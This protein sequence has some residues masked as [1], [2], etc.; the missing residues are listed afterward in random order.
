MKNRGRLYKGI[1]G[2]CVMIMLYVVLFLVQCKKS[3]G[4]P[5]ANLDCSKISS[6]YSANIRPI[7]TSAACSM[8][9]CHNA[10]SQY[11]DLTNYS[12]AKAMV[13]NGSMYL[14][15]VK[16]GNMPPSGPLPLDDRKRIKCWIDSG[17]PNN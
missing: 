7:F 6:A 16:Q 3:T 15:V 12:G 9:G 13:D 17:A 4:D 10:N 1:S 8:Q 11:G 2:A 5:F 14:R